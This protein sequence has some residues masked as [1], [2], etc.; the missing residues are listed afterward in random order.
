MYFNVYLS[1]NFLYSKK[2]IDVIESIVEA[3]LKLVWEGDLSKKFDLI[4]LIKS[5]IVSELNFTSPS[6]S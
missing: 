3:S 1:S 5:S 2:E 4:K 6:I